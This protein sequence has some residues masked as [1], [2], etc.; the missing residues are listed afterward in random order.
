MRE[1]QTQR[2]VGDF[3]K[4]GLLLLFT[5]AFRYQGGADHDGRQIWLGDESASECFH[6]DAGLDRTAAKPAMGFIDRQRQPAEIG[7]FLPDLGTEAERIG[8]H[9]AAVIGVIG[10][11]NEAVDAFAQQ[12]LLVAQGRGPFELLHDGGFSDGGM[13]AGGI[14]DHSEFLQVMRVT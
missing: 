12:S 8:R 9:A 6:Q 5:S 14:D 4:K 3:G 2:A 13:Q 7:E 1:R 11:G 10:L